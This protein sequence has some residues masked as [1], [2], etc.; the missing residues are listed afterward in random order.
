MR[1]GVWL[2]I[3]A[4]VGLVLGVVHYGGLWWTTRRALASKRP[5]QVMLASYAVRMV[6]V[7]AGVYGVMVGFGTTQ[8]RWERAAVAIVGMLVAR[9]LLVRRLGPKA[10]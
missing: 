5:A 10:T 9:T 4:A 8:P 7:M 3:A 1:D 6:I 2:A